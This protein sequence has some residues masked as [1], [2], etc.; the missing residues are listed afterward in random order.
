MGPW[1]GL[2][3][4][5]GLLL[6]THP[7]RL[8]EQ[9]PY[10]I[11][12]SLGAAGPKPEASDAA[13]PTRGNCCRVPRGKDRPPDRPLGTAAPAYG[14]QGRHPRG[15]PAPAPPPPARSRRLSAPPGRA[16]RQQPRATGTGTQRRPGG[17]PAGRRTHQR[18]RPPH[19]PS[20]RAGRAAPLPFTSR[21]TK[22]APGPCPAGRSAPHRPR[23]AAAAPGRE[24][25]ATARYLGCLAPPFRRR[26]AGLTQALA[27][28]PGAVR[29]QVR[30][31]HGGGRTGDDLC[32]ARF[33]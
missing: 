25:S 28:G 11:P 15:R 19:D 10:I 1:L 8:Q 2:Q 32:G 5:L 14:A 27:G 26:P 20:P 16:S 6:K 13:A 29:A 31:L 4:D 21:R 9:H 18:P 12:T 22:R 17:A 3:K 24:Q 33:R 7:P 30:E 23:P